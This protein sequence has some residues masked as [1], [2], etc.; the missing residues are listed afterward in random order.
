MTDTFASE[1]EVYE[2]GQAAMRSMVLV[3]HDLVHPVVRS[4]WLFFVD[5]LFTS[6]GH[7]VS[8]PSGHTAASWLLTLPGGHFEPLKGDNNAT[9]STLTLLNKPAWLL[10][11][12]TNVHK[13]MMIWYYDPSW[14]DS[15]MCTTASHLFLKDS[16][17]WSVEELSLIEFIDCNSIAIAVWAYFRLFYRMVIKCK[18]L[19]ESSSISSSFFD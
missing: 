13:F 12:P 15:T 2:V 5:L 7:N 6:K 19:C 4:T 14:L 17:F 16:T 10:G 8:L 18:P 1:T 9:R 3:L 11:A